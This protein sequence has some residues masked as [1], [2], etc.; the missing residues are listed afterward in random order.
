[1]LLPSNYSGTLSPMLDV[2]IGESLVI[3]GKIKKTGKSTYNCDTDWS[4]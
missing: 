1:M 3:S 4:S 2:V